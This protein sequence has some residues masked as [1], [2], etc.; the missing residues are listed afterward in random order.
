MLIALSYKRRND[1][2][3][4]THTHTHIHTSVRERIYIQLPNVSTPLDVRVREGVN[5]TLD[6]G[7]RIDA[8]MPSLVT[9]NVRT[10]WSLR[11]R[12]VGGG[13]EDPSNVTNAE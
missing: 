6:C 10:F 5:T 1:L 13:L 9:R 7:L 11:R 3:S 4:C 8:I 2:C 12:Q